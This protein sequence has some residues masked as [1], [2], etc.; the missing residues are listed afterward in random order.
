MSRKCELYT[1]TRYRNMDEDVPFMHDMACKANAFK[2]SVGLLITE[3]QQTA[4]VY[5][6]YTENG[7]DINEIT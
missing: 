6:M 4:Y 5:T 7:N 1:G 2:Q 3:A